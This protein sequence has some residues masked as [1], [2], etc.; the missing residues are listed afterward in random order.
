[1][2]AWPGLLALRALAGAASA[3]TAPAPR[4][5]TVDPD[6][7]AEISISRQGDNRIAVQAPGVTDPEQLRARIGQTALMTF[8]L[9]REVSPEEAAD[10]RHNAGA[11]V[12]GDQRPRP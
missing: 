2:R 9:V 12:S 7:T 10:V 11:A 3:Q 8:H 4:V 1:M 6:G 5:I